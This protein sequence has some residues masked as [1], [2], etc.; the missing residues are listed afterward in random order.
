MPAN[1]AVQH[2]NYSLPARRRESAAAWGAESIALRRR[3]AQDKLA[4]QRK[5]DLDQAGE[6]KDQHFEQKIGKEHE[7][8]SFKSDNRIQCL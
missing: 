3:G 5:G 4:D 8:L 6:K 1:G 7:Y 2:A